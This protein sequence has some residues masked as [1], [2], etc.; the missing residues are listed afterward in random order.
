MTTTARDAA[1]ALVLAPEDGGRDRLQ[2]CSYW[3]ALVLGTVGIAM[4]IN[5]TFN[6]NVFGGPIIDTGFFYIVLGLFL[7]LAFLAYPSHIAARHHIPWF[8]WLLFAAT[9]GCCGFLAWN[10]GRIVAEGWDLS[11]PTGA[12]IIA[13]CVCLLALEGLRRAGGMVLFGMC[14]IFALFPLFSDHM[15][16]F[17]WGPGMDLAQTVR[18]HAMGVES[19]IGV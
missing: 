12:T 15:P 14:T 13:G 8:D 18:A 6:L 4:T 19:I 3:V 9:L 7:S 1:P 2:G 10:G 17:L 11:A 5:Q 16:G